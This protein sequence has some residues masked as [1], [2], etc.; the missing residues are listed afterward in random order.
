MFTFLLAVFGIWL[1]FTLS[2][3][4]VIDTVSQ[5]TIRSLTVETVNEAVAEVMADNPSFVDFTVVEKDAQGNI[6]MVHTDSA[7]V[8]ALARAVT[9]RSQQSLDQIAEQ[10]VPIP[11]GSLSGI[12]VLAGRGPDVHIKA[13]PVG[14]IETVFDSQFIPAGINQTLHKL[15]INVTASVN[16]II[17]GTKNKVTTTAQVLVGET[18]LIGKVPDVYLGAQSSSFSFDLVP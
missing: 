13:I 10:G 2:V 12:S 4:P 3:R 11:I 16:I 14:N 9:I 15:F 18:I 5:E 17:P 6:S 8:N 1:F 7:A